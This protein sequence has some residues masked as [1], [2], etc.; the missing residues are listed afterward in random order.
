MTDAG[1]YRGTPA[2]GCPGFSVAFLLWSPSGLRPVLARA[3]YQG[4]GHAGEDPGLMG[5]RWGLCGCAE[6][7]RRSR[8]GFAV[9][10]NS[11]AMIYLLTVRDRSGICA[12]FGL[13]S[14]SSR[15]T[16]ASSRMPVPT[17]VRTGLRP[18]RSGSVSL[19]K[20]RGVTSKG[21]SGS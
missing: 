6:K 2:A 13:V 14:R 9:C 1:L 10:E 7:N 3:E 8:E 21:F 16:P 17:P 12:C 15:S 5:Y 20:F 4:A 11:T 19:P 18:S